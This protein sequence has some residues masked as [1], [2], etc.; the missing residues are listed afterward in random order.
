MP[1]PEIQ[2]QGDF[3]AGIAMRVYRHETGQWENLPDA[4]GVVT[5]LPLK[6]RFM[7]YMIRV[8]TRLKERVEK[9]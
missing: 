9:W 4:H 6:V 8:T 1:N 7:L 3:K 2:A 5:N